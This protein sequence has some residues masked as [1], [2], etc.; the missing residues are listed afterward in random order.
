MWSITT[1]PEIETFINSIESGRSS[2]FFCR[3]ADVKS[4][5]SV[6]HF[7]VCSNV[8]GSFSGT[9]LQ[10]IYNRVVQLLSERKRE[11][12]VYI[13]IYNVHLPHSHQRMEVMV[14]GASLCHLNW[15]H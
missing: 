8:G 1:K 12:Y 2:G 5:I 15:L 10:G 3:Q 9:S 7:S 14:R 6:G 11:R 4:S 13:Y